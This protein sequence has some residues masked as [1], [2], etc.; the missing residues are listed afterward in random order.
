MDPESIKTEL[1]KVVKAFEAEGKPL[2]FAGITPVYPG[3]RSTSYNFQVSGEFLEKN[4]DAIRTVVEKIFQVLP[5]ESRRGISAVQI[6]EPGSVLSEPLLY[7][8]DDWILVNKLNYKPDPV[9]YYRSLEA[10]D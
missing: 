2:T 5:P 6:Y 1:Y 8:S 9:R 3:L 10:D 7:P 4:P